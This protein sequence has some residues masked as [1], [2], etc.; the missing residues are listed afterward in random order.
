MMGKAGQKGQRTRS[1]GRPGS[2]YPG[3][4]VPI[5]CG[6]RVFFH[7]SGEGVFHCRLCGADRQYRRRSGRKFF[8]VFFIPLIPLTK[9]GEHVQCRTCGTRYHAG[10]LLRATV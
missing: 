6:I 9:V 7:P 3:V 8:A 2:H 1:P 5:V 10:V 4:T